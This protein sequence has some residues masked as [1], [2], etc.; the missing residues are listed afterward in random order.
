M[1]TISIDELTY[2][3]PGAGVPALRR[4]SVA[5]EPGLTVVVGASGSGKSTL[6]RLCNGLVPHLHGGRISGR[7]VVGGLDVLRTPTRRLAHQVGF[8]FQDLEA[9]AVFDLVDREVAF[10][11]ENLGVEAGAMP[12]RVEEALDRVGAL[13]LRG[14]RLTTLSGGERQ[15]VAIASAL[16]LRPSCLVLDEPTSQLDPAGADLVVDACLDLAREGHTVVAAEH[17]LERL[18][19]A[20]DRLAVVTGAHV[21]AG[22]PRALVHLAPTQPPL[23]ELGLRLGWQPLAL[24]P[25]ELDGRLPVVRPIARPHAR[26]AREAAVQVV[27]GTVAAGAEVLLEGVDLTVGTGEVVCLMGPNGGGKTTLLR[28]LAG[29][30]RPRSGRVERRAGRVA[31]LPQRP[32][33][34]L[35]QPTVR[36][37]IALTLRRARENEPA[38]RVLATLG[39]TAVADQFPRDLSTGQRQRVGI[40]AVLAGAPALALLDE[41]TRGIDAAA[42]RALRA[43]LSELR[44]RGT[45]IVLA[46][47]DADLA[48]YVADRIV[49]VGEGRVVELGPPDLALA[50]ERPLATQLGRLYPNGPVTVD[51]VLGA[52]A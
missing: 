8:V 28:V 32:D 23:V 30:V 15:R 39:L 50:G 20:A 52:R 25:A 3:Y 38:D 10:G 40:G 14:R 27:S 26:P 45:A 2:A 47:H 12:G 16:V 41:P 33:V 36:A 42:S 24:S 5:F 19:P 35:H 22:P 11:L 51:G 37:E 18:L 46:T 31:Y 34:L 13:G 49:R 48:A 4:A 6:L 17:R 43:V 21:I 9:Q 7:A 29:L 44:E 1:A